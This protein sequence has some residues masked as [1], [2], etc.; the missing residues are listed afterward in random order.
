[1][2]DLIYKDS[3]DP[4]LKTA[5]IVKPRVKSTQRNHVKRLVRQAFVELSPNITKGGLC[6]AVVKKTLPK[7]EKNIQAQLES[8]LKQSSFI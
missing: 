6:I 4:T 8:L 2:L 1:M 3:L 7:A 5:V